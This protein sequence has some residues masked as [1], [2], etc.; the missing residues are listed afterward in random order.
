MK[1]REGRTILLLATLV[2]FGIA[3]GVVSLTFSPGLFGPRP[4][5]QVGELVVKVELNTPAHTQVPVVNASVIIRAIPAKESSPQFLQTDSK[6]QLEVSL[7]AGDYVV[8]VYKGY[9][10]STTGAVPILQDK[11]TVAAVNVTLA[12]IKPTF[13]EFPD[14]DGTGFVSPWQQIEVTVNSSS[15]NLIIKSSYVFFDAAYA[16][17]GGKT[18]AV[19][20]VREML[21]FPPA[22]APGTGLWWF[23]LQLQT[24]LPVTGLSDLTLATYLANMEVEVPGP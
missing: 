17:I 11:T 5:K 3:L 1:L 24:F 8:G 6:G 4:N 9:E 19:G 7:D 13:T 2:V 23:T 12:V 14:Q 21:T 22:E 18:P 20:E 16:P 10:F 15:A